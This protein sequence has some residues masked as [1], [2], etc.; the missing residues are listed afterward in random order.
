MIV[1]GLLRICKGIVSGNTLT[2]EDAEVTPAV[3]LKRLTQDHH[4]GWY[5]VPLGEVVNVEINKLS[6]FKSHYKR[7]GYVKRSGFKKRSA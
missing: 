3:T 4:A 6:I 2:F 7:A 5:N 1:K